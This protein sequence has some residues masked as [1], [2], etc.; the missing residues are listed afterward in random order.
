MK[1][2][3][4][5]VWPH[6][7]DA[8]LQRVRSVRSSWKPEHGTKPIVVVEAAMLLDADWQNFLDG[9]WVITASQDVALQR[10]M[11]S[12]G[13]SKE[14]AEQRIQAQQSR[15]GIGNLDEEVERRTVTAVIDNSGSLEELREKLSQKLQDES[16]WYC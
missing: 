10:L 11:D 15:R 14:E 6:T 4:R 7:K 1:R 9:V 3:E 16:A 8:V 12:R 13:W 2:L 5:I